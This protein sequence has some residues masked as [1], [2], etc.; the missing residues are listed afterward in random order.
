MARSNVEGS[1]NGIDA[2]EAEVGMKEMAEN[3][4]EAASFILG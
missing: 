4:A 2:T 3:I 1:K